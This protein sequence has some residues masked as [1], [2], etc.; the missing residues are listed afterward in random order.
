M[1][2][3]GSKKHE[4]ILPSSKLVLPSHHSVSD[5]DKNP[6]AT[7][8]LDTGQY[9]SPPSSLRL[10]GPGS[11]NPD[12]AFICRTIETR[13]LPQGQLVTSW[14]ST[15]IDS[16]VMLYFRCQS[17]LG[18]VF[19][20]NT[21]RIRYIEGSI[22]LH[23]IV[24]DVKYAVGYWAADTDINTWWR[25]RFTWWNG[26]NLDGEDALTVMMERYIDPDWIQ[27][28]NWIYDT[29]N[30]WKDS[31]LNR[32]AI[33]GYEHAGGNFTWFDDTEIWAPS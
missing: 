28:D 18:I 19:L 22:A 31:D 21:Y 14:R 32:V 6:D 20:Q 1:N 27:I 9:V 4:L 24:G 23:R 13:N 5:W 17:A 11:T 33:G 30:R 2:K 15:F 16:D 10:S 25:D 8:T 12:T 26:R 3:R 29:N 7:Y